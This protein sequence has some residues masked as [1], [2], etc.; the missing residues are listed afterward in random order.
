MTLPFL[1]NELHLQ[2]QLRQLG[3]GLLRLPLQLAQPLLQPGV[4]LAT[5]RAQ[6]RPWHPRPH[7]SPAAH[8]EVGA[9]PARRLLPPQ[10]PQLPVTRLH[11][12]PQPLILSR[13]QVPVLLRIRATLRRVSV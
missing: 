8:L 11:L 13:Q 4:L 5:R 6:P 10:L 9:V 12:L 3:S 7:R 2:L 1:V